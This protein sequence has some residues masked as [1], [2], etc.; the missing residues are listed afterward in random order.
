MNEEYLKL[1]GKIHQEVEVNTKKI[2]K[3]GLK[4]IDLCNFIE[5]NIKELTLKYCETPQLNNGI[6]FPTGISIN[7]IA[8]HYTP[9]SSNEEFLNE[10]SIYK[11]DFGTHINGN[12]VDSAFS[13]NLNNKYK[14]ILDASREAV[15]NIIKNIGVDT[16]INEIGNL[17]HEIVSSYEFEGKTLKALDNLCGHNILPYKIHGGT[18]IF[19]I[20]NN[21]DNRRIKDGEVLAIEIFTSNGNGTTKIDNTKASSHFMVVN[22]DMFKKNHKFKCKRTKE[23]LFNIN[24][25]YKTLPFCPRFLDNTFKKSSKVCINDLFRNG[26]I[27]SHPPLI[28]TDPQSRVAQFEET[29]LI[30]D[31]GAKIIS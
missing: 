16:C 20:P 18:Y 15:D 1:A 17:S 5:N 13:I 28:E 7:E 14:E 30:K 31:T 24:N 12:I 4:I 3:P 10:E 23:L 11:I 21:Y 26:I 22:E 27:S 8:A 25:N 9:N 2:I 19:G 29:I 6:A